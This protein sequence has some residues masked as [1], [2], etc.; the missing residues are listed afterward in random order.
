MVAA[1]LLLK[2]GMLQVGQFSGSIGDIW[3]FFAK[4]FTEPYVLIG[5]FCVLISALSWMIAISRAE[6][7]RIYPFMGL[8][9]AL[10]ALFSWLFFKESINVWG[11]TGIAMI[12]VGV[13]LVLGIK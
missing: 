4:T 1:Q 5:I 8:T 10:V 3:P 6:M 11:W 9:F 7:S 2:K 13:F 12:T